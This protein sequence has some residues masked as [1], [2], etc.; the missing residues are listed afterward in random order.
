MKVDNFNNIPIRNFLFSSLLDE[1]VSDDP[2][3]SGVLHLYNKLHADIH[4]IDLV[5][6]NLVRKFVGSM[7]RNCEW[8]A[9]TVHTLVGCQTGAQTILANEKLAKE[10][11]Q[12]K[13]EM[14]MDRL[15]FAMSTI[16]DIV[17]RRDRV[18]AR[19][20]Q[21]MAYVM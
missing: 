6:I 2:Q 21:S 14:Q 13:G 11:L 12:E 10:A 1:E 15:D 20:Q 5:R 3:P 17:S 9:I 4:E 18:L 16:H 7:I 19:D 8:M